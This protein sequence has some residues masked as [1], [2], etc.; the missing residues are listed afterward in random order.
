MIFLIVLAAMLM[1]IA[2]WA[3]APQGAKQPSVQVIV[4]TPRTGSLPQTLTAYG[5][6]QASPDGGSE[7][8]SLL[9]G[10]QVTEVFTYT[11][12]PIHKGQPLLVVVPRPAKIGDRGHGY[13]LITPDD[14]AVA[15]RGQDGKPSR[16]GEYIGDECL[17]VY[18]SLTLQL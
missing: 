15:L 6:V 12:Q 1:P 3:Q 18:A 4:E 2:A 16:R 14:G 13:R 5:T 17:H 8:M 9:R 11:G 10:G 7:T